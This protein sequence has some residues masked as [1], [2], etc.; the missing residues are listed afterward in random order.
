MKKNYM[1]VG[2]WKM[3]KPYH[4]S[5]TYAQK[6]ASSLDTHGHTVVICP[7]FVALAQCASI[8]KSSSIALGAQDCS[9]HES[10][11]YTGQTDAQSL[12]QIGCQF[13]IVGHTEQRVV[14]HETDKT[15]AHQAARLITHGITPIMCI[16]EEFKQEQSWVVL[17][18]SRVE[19]AIMME[20]L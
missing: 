5:L 12:A 4:E 10:G 2:N 18:F 17:L 19:F 8:F 6:L 20:T 7:S 16:G 14:T 13:G 3:N 15:I 9:E 1:I 11:A